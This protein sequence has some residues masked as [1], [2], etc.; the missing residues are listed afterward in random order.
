MVHRNIHGA[1][2][3]DSIWLRLFHQKGGFMHKKLQSSSTSRDQP[4]LH[5]SK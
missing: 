2:R 1:G 4:G 3:I 5:R